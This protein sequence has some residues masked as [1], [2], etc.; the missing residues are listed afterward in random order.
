MAKTDIFVANTPFVA[1]IAD[2]GK[3]EKGEPTTQRFAAR[4]GQKFHA[5][6]PLVKLA[7]Q[8]FDAEDGAAAPVSYAPNEAATAAPGELRNR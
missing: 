4:T 3:D 7:P 6:H 1:D 8:Y 2:G 5:N